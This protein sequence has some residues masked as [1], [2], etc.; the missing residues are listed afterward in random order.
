MKAEDTISTLHRLREGN[1]EAVLVKAREE[2]R[3]EESL[4][5]YYF[6]HLSIERERRL[7][8]ERRGKWIAR[9]MEWIA[10][11]TEWKLGMGGISS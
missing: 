7:L 11:E 5:S 8:D 6:M 4:A 3:T 9:K 10:I 2:E 1:D